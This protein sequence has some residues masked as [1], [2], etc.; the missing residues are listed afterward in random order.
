MNCC[1]IFN[2]MSVIKKTTLHCELPFFLFIHKHLLQVRSG[3]L[4]SGQVCLLHYNSKYNVIHCP[5]RE[6]TA[7][8]IKS[9]GNDPKAV[10][11]EVHFNLFI[12][13]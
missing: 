12:S 4:R 9:G 11:S 5:V 7:D 3:Q 2:K 13:S 1:F 10:D 6:S 8:K